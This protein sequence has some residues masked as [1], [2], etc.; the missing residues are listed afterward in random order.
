VTRIINETKRLEEREAAVEELLSVRREALR[1]AQRELDESLSQLESC[2][3]RKKVLMSR[4]VEMTRRGL[5]S[6]DELEEAERADSAA[7][8]LAVEDIHSL[9][10]SDVLDIID[11]PLSHV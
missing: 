10:H 9:V 2:R 4:G 11:A 7:E 3:K 1:V 5:D 8:Q 6:L